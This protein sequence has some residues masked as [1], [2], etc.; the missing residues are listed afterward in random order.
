M[1]LHHGIE[2]NFALYPCHAKHESSI[3]SVS[4]MT[5]GKL[6]RPAEKPWLESRGGWKFGRNGAPCRVNIRGTLDHPRTCSTTQS[7][8]SMWCLDHGQLQCTRKRETRCRATT[9]Q[10]AG[11]VH[12]AEWYEGYSYHEQSIRVEWYEERYME[13]NSDLYTNRLQTHYG[14]NTRCTEK[15]G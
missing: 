13:Y 3:A 15:I 14:W 8:Q 2:A 6:R 9:T 7:M 4:T 1:L 12:T 10:N 5:Q 11:A